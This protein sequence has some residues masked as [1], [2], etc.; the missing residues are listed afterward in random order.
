MEF[1]DLRGR[2]IQ[3][4]TLDE[5]DLSDVSLNLK[6]EFDVDEARL[7]GDQQSVVGEGRL[8]RS[9]IV[10]ANLSGSVLTPLDVQDVR[11]S[12]VD[13]SNATFVATTA[14]RIELLNCRGVGL[15]LSFE[16]VADL[17]VEDCR[18]D[19]AL[20]RIDRSK[21]AVVFHRCSFREATIQGDLSRVAFVDCDF[22]GAEFQ[23]QRAEG[24][25]LSDSQ[26]AGA[27]GLLTLRGAEITRDQAVSVADVLATEAGLVVQ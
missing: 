22:G 13:L 21:G 9:L 15:Q 23:V 26:L 12:E 5:D 7:V 19:Y 10:D 20:V 14:R 16:L 17:F 11:L 4:P 27:Q 25:D 1:R 24:C 3:R 2:S 6:G 18:M 8:R